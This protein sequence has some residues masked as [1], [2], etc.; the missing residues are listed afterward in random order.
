MLLLPLLLLAM[1]VAE[2]ATCSKSGI[3]QP[4]VTTLATDQTAVRM[5]DV[6][7]TSCG[8]TQINATASENPG[9]Y[10]IT[11]DAMGIVTVESYPAVQS[12]YVEV[13]GWGCGLI[14]TIAAE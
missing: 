12:L 5:A 7:T 4:K 3:A 9:E 14:L 11:A 8:E 10:L 2:A 6:V 13:N 1:P